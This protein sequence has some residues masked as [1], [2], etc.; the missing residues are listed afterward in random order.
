[1]SRHRFRSQ[2]ALQRS[3]DR[4][5]FRLVG[6]AL[7][8]VVGIG[9]GLLVGRQSLERAP[10]VVGT[11][12]GSST[13][14]PA[15]AGSPAP[16]APSAAASPQADLVSPTPRAAVATVSTKPVTAPRLPRKVRPQV[17]SAPEPSAQEN[18]RQQQQDY[19]RARAAYD[20]SERTAGF[21][22]AQQNKIRVV[23]YCRVAAQRTPAF[24]EGCLNYLAPGRAKSREQ[25]SPE[26]R[27]QG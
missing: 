11:Y 26:T 23:R 9:S 16:A 22:W 21:Q 6:I 19:E 13:D 12:P 2:P 20:A 25:S 1:M 15:T 3:G 27:E 5:S 4:Q 17:V 14:K 18:W 10:A 8:A 24:V 7:L